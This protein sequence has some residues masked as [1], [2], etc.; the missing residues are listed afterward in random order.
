MNTLVSFV[1]ISSMI[2]IAAILGN[3]P[4]IGGASNTTSANGTI[5]T[6]SNK[7]LGEQQNLSKGIIIG[8][9]GN[10]T[11]RHIE[12]NATQ[13]AQ[14]TFREIPTSLFYLLLSIVVLLFIPVIVDLWLA[15]R[16]NKM[17]SIQGIIRG[18]KG[19]PGLY[20]ALMT[21]GIIILVGVVIIYVLALVAFNTTIQS[22][23]TQALIEVLRN[24]STI[25]GTAL[26]TIIAFYFGIR[27]SEGAIE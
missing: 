14:Q 6:S 23:A 16:R 22:P 4:I 12:I 19:M 18:P 25:L 27:G 21:F 20:R 3:I 15:H 7:T 11:T 8:P 24:L 2:L 9:A 17:S 5:A 1:S 13:V 26:A 10:F